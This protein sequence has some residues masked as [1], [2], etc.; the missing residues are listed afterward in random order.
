MWSVHPQPTE[1][2]RCVCGAQIFENNFRE[3]ES[4]REFYL[5]GRGLCQACQDDVYL[6]ANTDEPGGYLPIVDGALVAVSDKRGAI[7]EICFLPFRFAA[8]SR[9]RIAWEA[10]FI[11]RAGTRL[12]RLDPWDELEP[13]RER[14][15]GHQVQVSEHR[16]FHSP[17]LN[18][19]LDRLRV[20][21]GLD[22]PSLDIALSLCSL[23]R[24][25]SPA[26][27]ADEVPWC[28]AFARPLRPLA[29][30]WEAAPDHG[31][32]LRTCALMGVVLLEDGRDGRRPL[33]YLIESRKE[34]FD[35]QTPPRS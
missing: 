27:L 33:D 24:G 31:T 4:Y 21:I 1:I 32:A 34:L 17:E 19:R 12:E 13:M 16:S 14:L 23:P 26:S 35:R 30:W 25:A 22:R 6:G 7:D 29:T 28:A 10:R 15:T 9:A 8:P 18:E 20:L 3:R 5:G 11:V 2:G